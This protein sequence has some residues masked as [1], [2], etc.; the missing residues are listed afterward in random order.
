MVYHVYDH[1]W[2]ESTQLK[3][4]FL[5]KSVNLADGFKMNDVHFLLSDK[6]ILAYN[7]LQSWSDIIIKKFCFFSCC[8]KAAV[9]PIGHKILPAKDVFAKSV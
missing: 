3:Q 2:L 5:P 6:F 9:I 4:L 7:I 8:V 1:S